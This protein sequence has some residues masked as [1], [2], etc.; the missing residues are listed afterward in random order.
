MTLK[1]M[2]AELRASHPKAFGKATDAE[3]LRVTSRLLAKIRD[4]VEACEEGRVAVPS[5]GRFEVRHPK[6]P[7]GE[8]IRVV[9]Y[10]AA[11]PAAEKPTAEK[12]ASAK[13]PSGKPKK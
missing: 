4:E 3:V 6:N 12:P 2:I 9:R 13:P 1:E 10:V 7:K 11:K 5:F 8:T